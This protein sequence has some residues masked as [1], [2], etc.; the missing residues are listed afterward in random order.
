M[1][2]EKS[3]ELLTRRLRLRK[4]SLTNRETPCKQRKELRMPK[5]Q[6]KKPHRKLQTG[7]NKQKLQRRRQLKRW[8]MLKR[9]K[10]KKKPNSK[11]EKKKTRGSMMKP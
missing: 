4:R 7:R 5:K 3:K 6:Q 10:R 1:L 2:K 11:Q 8:L 9:L